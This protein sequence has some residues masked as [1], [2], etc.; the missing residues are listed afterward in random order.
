MLSVGKGQLYA[1]QGRAS[2]N[3]LAAQARTL[4]Q[5]DAELSANYN[6]PLAHG[7]WDL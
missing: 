1:K 2:T 3:D 7:K 5:A 6:H 4:F